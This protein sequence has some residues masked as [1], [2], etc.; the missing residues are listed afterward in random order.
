MTRRDGPRAVP[1]AARRRHR[2]EAR[3]SSSWTTASG[4]MQR[5]AD[6]RVRRRATPGRGGLRGAPRRPREPVAARVHGRA[7]RSS[8]SRELDPAE[9]EL[10]AHLWCGDRRRRVATTATHTTHARAREAAAT[11]SSSSSSRATIRDGDLRHCPDD[12]A[13]ARALDGRPPVAARADA[14]RSAS[15]L[16]RSFRARDLVGSFGGEELRRRRARHSSASRTAGSCPGRLTADGPSYV[17]RSDT[18]QESLYE[19]LSHASRRRLHEAAGSWFEREYADDLDPHLDLLAHHF[20][21]SANSSKQRTYFALAGRRAA[22]LFANDDA[23]DYFERLVERARRRRRCRH[24]PRAA[25][26]CT[27]TSADRSRPRRSSA[28]PST[29]ARRTPIPFSLAALGRLLAEH[30]LRLD[31]ARALL[32]EAVE[33]AEAL[34][35]DAARLAVFSGLAIAL[36]QAGDLRGAERCGREH[37]ELAR[38]LDDPLAEA[39]RADR[40]RGERRGPGKARRVVPRAPHGAPDRRGSPRRPPLEDRVVPLPG[41]RAARRAAA[42]RRRG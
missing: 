5:H 36:G 13:G 24:A 32:T 38:R 1:R 41:V 21:R 31:E 17:F 42:R 9:S 28:A 23:I 37:L 2:R 19:S 27:P 26:S 33:R 39:D 30:Q 34:G 7:R 16:G 40:H 20:G 4:R 10:L 14:I 18:M 11:R 25:V 35:D 3:G 15:V 29:S 22:R 12:V 6:D 8:S